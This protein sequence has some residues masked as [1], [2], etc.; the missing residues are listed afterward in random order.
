MSVCLRFGGGQLI[1]LARDSPVRCLRVTKPY[2]KHLTGRLIMHRYA[3][4]AAKGIQPGALVAAP[5]NPPH[6]DHLVDDCG[7]PDLKLKSAQRS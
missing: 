1:S 5:H 7:F 2:L 3:N 4:K 6:F